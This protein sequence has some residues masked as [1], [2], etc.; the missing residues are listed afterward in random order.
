MELFHLAV[1]RCWN[2]GL[3]LRQAAVRL[4]RDGHVDSQHSRLIA[5]WRKIRQAFGCA[6]IPAM[7]LYRDIPLPACDEK[8]VKLYTQKELEQSVWVRGMP[9]VSYGDWLGV[10]GPGQTLRLTNKITKDRHDEKPNETV[11]TNT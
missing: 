8:P 5:E 1:R 4:K 2:A 9:C 11:D 6:S 7:Y 10:T 3:S